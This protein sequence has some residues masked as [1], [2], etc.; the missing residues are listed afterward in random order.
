[1]SQLPAGATPPPKPPPPAPPPEVLF[2]P[3]AYGP[4]KFVLAPL[5]FPDTFSAELE[6][7]PAPAAA[8]AGRLF[9]PTAVGHEQ[10]VSRAVPLPGHVQRGPRAVARA[11][12][13]PVGSD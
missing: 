13:R 10:F 12:R 7:L 9:D 8:P 3:L 11:C 1:T 2:E 6:P 4:P 5:P